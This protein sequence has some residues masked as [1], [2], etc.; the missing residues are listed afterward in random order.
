MKHG[1]LLSSSLSKIERQRSA[2]VMEKTVNR[3]TANHCVEIKQGRCSLSLRSAGAALRV[4]YGVAQTALRESRRGSL[5]GSRRG[6]KLR[7]PSEGRARLTGGCHSRPA[8]SGA[9]YAAPA[10][11]VSARA[12]A[13]AGLSGLEC[14]GSVSGGAGRNP[15]SVGADGSLGLGPDHAARRDGLGHSST[16][17]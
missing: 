6:L 2:T 12:S 17:C 8:A 1:F 9:R 11:T 15:S 13:V 14:C 5:L 3:A 7:A 4:G 16:S 10:G